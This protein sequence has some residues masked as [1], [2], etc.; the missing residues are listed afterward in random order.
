[1][2]MTLYVLGSVFLE[3][4]EQR[5]EDRGGGKSRLGLDLAE[6]LKTWTRVCISFKEQ[7][8][9]KGF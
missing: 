4:H 1:M 2:G 5:G 3:L 9:P 6:P 8:A 7:E